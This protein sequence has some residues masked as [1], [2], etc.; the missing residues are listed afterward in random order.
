M[1]KKRDKKPGAQK[2]KGSEEKKRQLRITESR[3]APPIQFVPRR[4]MSNIE[5]PE[6]FI[7]VSF[8]QALMEYMKPLLELAEIQNLV[9]LDDIASLS[10][11]IW[12]YTSD[13]DR[14]KTDPQEAVSMRNVIKNKLKMDDHDA[15]K[16]LLDMIERKGRLFPSEIQPK[17]LGVIFLKKQISHLIA[18]FNYQ[19]LALLPGP[20]PPDK[21]DLAAMETI[22]KMDRFILDGTEYDEW[23]DH[24]FLMEDKC[25]A[26][27]KK[28]LDD[29][30]LS[31]YSRYFVFHVETYLNFIYRYMHE[32]L[33][34]LKSVPAKCFEEFFFDYLLRKLMI[35]PHEYPECPAAVKFFYGFLNEKGYVV[36]VDSTIGVIDE[37]EPY[38]IEVLR[39]RFG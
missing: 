10:T 39:K 12:N 35:E 27:F 30:G 16:L 17:N 18:S 32:D 11:S 25:C 3:K 28:W 20:I 24:Y 36:E 33:V 38:F 7:T 1:A 19:R 5:A 8:G 9:V 34:L 6:G 37:I 22:L 29:K 14:Q 2:R 23:E 15:N 13:L 31:E 26:R 21:E 4:I